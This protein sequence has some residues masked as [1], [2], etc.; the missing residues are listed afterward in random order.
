MTNGFLIIALTLLNFGAFVLAIFISGDGI[1]YPYADSK[2]DSVS[3]LISRDALDAFQCLAY[4]GMLCASFTLLI[5]ITK[6]SRGRL[7]SKQKLLFVGLVST[8]ISIVL[9]LVYR[10]ISLSNLQ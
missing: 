7:S 10:L 5:S 8:S 9:Y 1:L 2:E 4:L 6:L 3:Q